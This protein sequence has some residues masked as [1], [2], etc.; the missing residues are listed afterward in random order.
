MDGLCFGFYLTIGNVPF[1]S[2]G[3]TLLTFGWMHACVSQL[4][5]ISS[6]L[7]KDEINVPPLK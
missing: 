1:E 5:F 3:L 2:A 6:L 4:A 7:L